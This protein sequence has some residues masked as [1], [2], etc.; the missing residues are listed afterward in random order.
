LVAYAVP[1]QGGTAVTASKE[2]WR[3]RIAEWQAIY[4][5]I[6]GDPAAALDPTFNIAGWRS[7]YTGQA[8]SAAEMREW[9]DDTVSRILALRPQRVLEIG[10]GTG[11]LLFRVAPHCRSYWATDFSRTALQAIRRT[12]DSPG[13]ELTQVRLFER[14][15]D[16]FDG[17]QVGSVDLVIIN[18]VVQ[19]FPGLEYLARVVA[20]AAG[21]LAPGGHLL[22]GDV[23]SLP[24][25]STF[26]ASVQLCQVSPDLPV[27]DLRRLVREAVAREEELVVDPAFFAGLGRL[28]S[29]VGPARVLLKRGACANELNRFRYDVIIA[30]DPGEPP[31]PEPCRWLAWEEEGWTLPV[32][33]Q[34]LGETM[35]GLLGIFGVPNARLA[36]D[37]ELERLL[38]DPAGP[39]TAG[40]IRESLAALPESG[41]D[42]AELWRLGEALGFAVEI[43]W[44][45][46]GKGRFDAIFRDSR[47]AWQPVAAPGFAAAPEGPAELANDP[48]Q[49]RV[50]QRLAST[51]RTWLQQH[52]PPYMM[53]SDFVLLEALP[54]TPNGK[55]DRHALPVP[56]R[57]SGR[58]MGVPRNPLEQKLVEIWGEVLGIE[59]VG[60]HDNFFELGGHS[61]LATQVMARAVQSLGEEVP[62]RTLFE[63]P[64]VAGLAASFGRSQ[65]S[66]RTAALPRIETTPRD[67]P[68]PL[69]YSQL[70]LWLLDR[71]SPGNVTYSIPTALRMEGSLDPAALAASLSEIVRRHEV[72]RTTFVLAGDEPVQV[73]APPRLLPVPIV[74]LSEL[75]GERRNAVALG[76]KAADAAHPFDLA[77]GPLLRVCLLRFGEREHWALANLHHIVGDGW[78]VGL[79]IHELAALYEA[80]IA[81][82]PSPLLPLPVQYADY[83]QWQRQTLRGA[84]FAALVAYW[85]QHLAGAP[86]VQTHAGNL[87]SVLVPRGVVER[88]RAAGRAE[89]ATLFMSLLA[90]FGALLR[91]STRG[92]D[93]VIGTSIAGRTQ[94]EVEGLIGFFVN[95]LALRLKTYGD[96]DVSTLLREARETALGAFAN[97]DLPFEKL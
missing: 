3:L 94:V 88:L 1:R 84:R 19:Y 65:G 31:V 5:N 24:L 67:R 38:A 49:A 39:T 72:L 91:R 32:F 48:L 74:D 61:L 21:L 29:G 62:L 63:N 18:S 68:V 37:V 78:S 36:V 71:L 13:L 42:P 82:R 75:P 89:A 96:P 85:R 23:R 47:R 83:A 57:R 66:A 59:Q 79:L 14:L 17:L 6:Y 26:H 15:A 40:V 53:P 86:A 30:A 43:S 95:T 81:G 35:P 52:L 28:E 92:E 45:V 27:A 33:A 12:L 46:A 54:L 11:L 87:L 90:A 97:Q 7:S 44:S 80:A 10:C 64:T 76:L 69:S 34:L 20:G 50:E 70:R 41:V 60:V 8:L 4:D 93:L 55:L 51:L 22:V 9:V 16:D 56:S 2:E 58:A 25:L 77:V 73:I